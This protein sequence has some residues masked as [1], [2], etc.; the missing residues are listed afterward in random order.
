[1]IEFLIVFIV[2]AIILC[3]L[4]VALHF[5]RPPVYQISRE[6][7]LALM[8]ALVAGELTEIKWLVFIGHAIPM[9]PELNEI[10]LR[11]S[12]IELAAEQSQG[13]TFV[14]NPKRYDKAGIEQV[15]LVIAAL[16]KLIIDTPISKEF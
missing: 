8:K 2:T 12:A 11:C 7:A 15:E 1:M 16:E 13:I 6:D 14:A 5:G 4:A 3:G 10:R 9:D